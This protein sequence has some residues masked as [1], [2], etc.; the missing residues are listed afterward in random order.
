MGCCNPNMCAMMQ[1]VVLV[2][3]AAGAAALHFNGATQ[4]RAIIERSLTPP[5]PAAAPGLS[6]QA[7]SGAHA[8]NGRPGATPTDPGT[9]ATPG[10]QQPA[11]PA[12]DPNAPL[13][14]DDLGEMITIEQA[15]KIYNLPYEDPKAPQVIFL[16]ARSPQKYEQGHILN[17]YNLTP[18][19]FFDGTLPDDIDFWPKN[20]II[21]VYCEGGECDASHLVEA[22]LKEQKA[23]QR[24]YLIEAGFPGWQ[25]AGLPTETGSLPSN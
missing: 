12:A 22:R 9:D 5:T 16:D 15:V 1:A 21:V 20:S 19:S 24:V 3:I 8:A 23:F 11:Q 17:A 10:Y 4:Q 6:P 7:P 18:E 25:S 2:G 14:L 13:S